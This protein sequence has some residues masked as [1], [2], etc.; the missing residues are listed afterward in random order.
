MKNS[1][2]MATIAYNALD[3]KL[4]GDI[5]VLDIK[6]ISVMADYFI[7]ATGKNKNHVQ[8]LCDF[9]EEKLNKSGYPTK[10]K[11]GTKSGSWILMDFTD[12]IVHIFDAE[13]RAFY[14]LEKIWSDG[15]V[16]ENMS[17]L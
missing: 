13:N 15:R 10:T 5:K 14:D 8:T 7:I 3:E 11:E 1:K 9:T 17:E 4:G 2:E 12:I 6:G 16:I